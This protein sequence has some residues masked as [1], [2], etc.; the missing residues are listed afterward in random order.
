MS[1]KKRKA[2]AD[3]IPWDDGESEEEEV[4]ASVPEPPPHEGKELVTPKLIH[5]LENKCNF[6]DKTRKF[7][8]NLVKERDEYGKG[9]YKGGLKTFNGRRME[10][11]AKQE[12]G[13]FLQYM[14]A[15]I[16]EE[17]T[18]EEIDKLL[19]RSIMAIGSLAQE[20]QEMKNRVENEKEMDR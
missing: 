3:I 6:S 7:L 5:F 8:V 13:D 12:I 4:K 2:E 9:K 10:K 15:C 11:D 20:W 18:S 14:Y 17:N 1:D 16:M 19:K